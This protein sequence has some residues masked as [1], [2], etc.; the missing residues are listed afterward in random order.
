[1]VIELLLFQHISWETA[2]LFKGKEPFIASRFRLKVGSIC[3]LRQRWG[4]RGR[5]RRAFCKGSKIGV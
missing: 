5:A 2:I 1:M 4:Q 3:R